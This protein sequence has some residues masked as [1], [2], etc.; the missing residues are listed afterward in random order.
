MIRAL[1]FLLVGI[2]WIY[3]LL[4]LIT[5]DGVVVRNLPK[6]VWLLLVLFFPLIGS[7]AWL[8]AGR[9]QRNSSQW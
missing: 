1:P 6:T 7:I 4:D 5:T 8:V 9:P 2:L 3:C